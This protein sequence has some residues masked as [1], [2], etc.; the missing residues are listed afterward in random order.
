MY[1]YLNLSP[2]DS[3]PA[4]TMYYSCPVRLKTR[5]ISGPSPSEQTLCVLHF[6]PESVAGFL[7][8]EQGGPMT[9]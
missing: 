4:F 9:S 6:F 1:K 2:N 3:V 8:S 7:V 5:N